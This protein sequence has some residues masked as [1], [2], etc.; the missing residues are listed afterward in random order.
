MLNPSQKL[1]IGLCAICVMFALFIVHQKNQIDELRNTLASN[2]LQRTEKR[3][4]RMK[5][6]LPS[7]QTATK[8]KEERNGDMPERHL[9]NENRAEASMLEEQVKEIVNLP[10]D[11]DYEKI[12][13]MEQLKEENEEAYKILKECLEYEYNALCTDHEKRQA[14]LDSLNPEFLPAD[15]FKLLQDTLKAKLVEDEWNL[16]FKRR[17]LPEGSHYDEYGRIYYT[18]SP[19]DSNM[20]NILDIISEYCANAT[21]LDLNNVIKYLEELDHTMYL[22]CFMMILP[23]LKEQ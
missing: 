22:G 5:K 16:A 14:M 1:A 7:N 11:N 2:A 21:G 13:T 23:I 20:P 8:R 6:S 17:P 3:L 4:V 15:K 12:I 9:R 19:N 18:Y 10:D